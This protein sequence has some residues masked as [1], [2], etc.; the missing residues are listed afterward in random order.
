LQSV[1][2]SPLSPWKIP[3]RIH[4]IPALPLTPTGKIDKRLLEQRADAKAD[5]I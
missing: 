4:L 1:L 5:V 2:W 3:S